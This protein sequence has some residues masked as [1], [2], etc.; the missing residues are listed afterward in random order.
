MWVFIIPL[1]H[2]GNFVAN[3]ERQR[4]RGSR[5]TK[6]TSQLSSK[7]TID[8]ESWSSPIEVTNTA[9]VGPRLSLRFD[10]WP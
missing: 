10:E 6:L 3:F 1:G 5:D 7:S 4:E 9:H 2:V 8:C